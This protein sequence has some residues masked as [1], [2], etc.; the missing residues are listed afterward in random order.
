MTR[1]WTKQKKNYPPLKLCTYASCPISRFRAVPSI[2]FELEI[3]SF[4]WKYHTQQRQRQYQRWWG[5]QI[6]GSYRTW[7]ICNMFPVHVWVL[8][9]AFFDNAVCISVT[10]SDTEREEKSGHVT[11]VNFRCFFF[12]NFDPSFASLHLHSGGNGTRYHS[13][14]L[15]TIWQII[16]SNT[17]PRRLDLLFDTKVLRTGLLMR[18]DLSY[19]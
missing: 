6:H 12:V 2:Q 18:F 9:Y 10:E 14:L 15:H 16:K 19:F 5:R 13:R 17:W 3:K 1:T 8:S 11:R 7:L 4:N